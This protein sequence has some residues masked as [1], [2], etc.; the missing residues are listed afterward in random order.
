MRASVGL[1]HYQPTP[2]QQYA[3]WEAQAV[4]VQQRAVRVWKLYCHTLPLH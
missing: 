3:V 4:T 1:G 2:A